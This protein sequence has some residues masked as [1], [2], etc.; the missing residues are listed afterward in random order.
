MTDGLLR[1]VDGDDGGIRSLVAGDI[2]DQPIELLVQLAEEGEIDP[3]DLDLIAVTD[4]FLDRID[5]DDLVVTA[6]TLFYASVLLRLKSDAILQQPDP[7]PEEP[8]PEDQPIAPREGDPLASLERE[9]DRRLTRK[10]TRGTPSTLMELIHELRVAERERFWK[11]SRSYDTSGGAARG[12]QTLDYREIATGEGASAAVD[13]VSNTPHREDLEGVM[14]PVVEHLETA[15]SRVD[16]LPFEEL[17]SVGPSPARVFQ[18]LVFLEHRRAVTLD[19]AAPF[20]PL[21]VEPGPDGLEVA[22]DPREDD[23]DEPAGDDP[24]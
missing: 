24:A 19:Q 4:A 8:L 2:G 14:V 18:A 22:F 17:V 23:A 21:A 15:F 16:R 6:R 3:W 20:E 5:E 12:S 13:S 10:S 1:A 9:M 11:E 7:E